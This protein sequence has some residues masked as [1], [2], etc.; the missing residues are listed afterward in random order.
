MHGFKKRKGNKKVKVEGKVKRV[1]RFYRQN[2]VGFSGSYT[3][4]EPPQIYLMTVK[5]RLKFLANIAKVYCS[6]L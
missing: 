5:R 3:M 2:D 4:N 1:Q 6:G